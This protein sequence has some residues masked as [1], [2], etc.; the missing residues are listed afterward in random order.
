MVNDQVQK[1]AKE[2]QRKPYVKPQF[3]SRGSVF[4][5]TQGGKLRP[6]D[7]PLTGRTPGGS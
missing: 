4:E 1:T 7:Q 2:S 6:T 5:I 3:Q